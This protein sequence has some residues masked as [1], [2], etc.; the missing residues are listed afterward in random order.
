MERRRAGVGGTHDVLQHCHLRPAMFDG[1]HTRVELPSVGVAEQPCPGVH[2]R[3][4]RARKA[5]DVHVVLRHRR[6][7][8]RQNVAE[9]CEIRA[10]EQAV[11]LDNGPWTCGNI[12]ARDV[13]DRHAASLQCPQRGLQSAKVRC[14]AEGPPGGHA[15][16]RPLRGHA[17]E[18]L[19]GG[20]RRS[21]SCC[22]DSSSHARAPLVEPLRQRGWQGHCGHRAPGQVLPMCVLRAVLHRSRNARR[23]ACSPTC[24]AACPAS[25]G[26]AS[27]GCLMLPNWILPTVWLSHSGLVVPPAGARPFRLLF[28]YLPATTR[29]ENSIER[30][31]ASPSA[32]ACLVACWHNGHFSTLHEG[33]CARR[34]QHGATR[35]PGCLALQLRECQ[36]MEA[37][38]K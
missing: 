30:E 24:S 10:A 8:P 31:A 2:S 3:E 14:Q 5:G 9:H 4:G 25:S 38:K 32:P 18:G 6:R 19:L 35:A 13:D 1:A 34:A 11:G 27:R 16:E 21:R 17:S 7:V 26:R 20:V 23:A 37:H 12:A 22:N 36:T 33:L 15:S 28:T 29:C